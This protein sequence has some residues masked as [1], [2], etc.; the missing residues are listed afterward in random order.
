MRRADFQRHLVVFAQIEG[1]H[2]LAPAQVPEVDRMAI[3]VGHQIL[4]HDAVFILRRQAPFRADHVIARQVPPEIIVLVLRATVHFIAADDVERLAIHDEDARG[5]VGAVLAAAA[6]CADINAFGAAVDGVRTGIAGLGEQFLGFDDLVDLGVPRILDVDHIDARAADAGDD[7]VAA[8][9]KGV[10]GQGRQ[11]R[12]AGVPAE[13][14][15]FVALV[16]HEQAVDDLAI[17]V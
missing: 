4:G 11:C 1:L 13:M 16:G 2:H 17:G 12:R 6:Q 5:A 9:Q 14:V 15:K 3:F 10:P 7:Q 8:F